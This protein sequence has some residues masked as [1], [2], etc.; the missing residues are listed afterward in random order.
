MTRSSENPKEWPQC[1]EP[2]ATTL[3]QFAQKWIKGE[4]SDGDL[5]LEIIE[6]QQ[7]VIY[8]ERE[9]R[10][11][12]LRVARSIGQARNEISVLAQT[13]AEHHA[14]DWQRPSTEEDRQITFNVVLEDCRESGSYHRGR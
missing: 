2:Y 13:L 10:E 9:A 12:G 14:T 1:G 5:A 11:D 6:L 3:K 4:M 7:R 8:A